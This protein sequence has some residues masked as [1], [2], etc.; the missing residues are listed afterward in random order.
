MKSLQDYIDKYREIGTNLGYTG[1]GIEVLV[2]LL[3]NASYIS[4]VENVS[5]MK[6]ASLE[7]CAL[8]NSKI[9]HCVDS[10]YSVFRGSCPRVL[11]KIKPT[12]YMTLTPY[13][14]IITSQTFKVYYL[15]YYTGSEF[16]YSTKTF[17]P[18]DS[19]S[20]E[21]QTIICLIAKETV[22]KSWTINAY[23][24]Y[25]VDCYESNLS[26]DMYVEIG[27][28][29]VNS[30]RLFSDHILKHYV[31]DLTL[32]D[33]GSRLYVANYYK[34]T[35]GRS[36]TDIV[37]MTENETIGATYFKFSL[38]G[39]Y[40]Q[41]ELTR[42]KLQGA[43]LVSFTNEEIIKCTNSTD[44]G[45]TESA[46]GI[47]YIKEISRDGLVTIHYK[48]NRDRYV[49]SILR[50][51]SD[52]GTVLEEAYPNIIKSGGTSYTFT[53]NNS[54][55]SIVNI[56][57][58]PMSESVLLSAD[59]IDLFKTEKRA[60]YVITDNITVNKGTRYIATFNISLELFNSSNDDLNTLIGDNIL[61][62]AYQR[63][64]NIEF[65]TG[66]IEEIKSL[67]SKISNV[68]R[69]NQLEIGYSDSNNVEVDL[70]KIDPSTSYFDI[71]YSIST[72]V[73]QTNTDF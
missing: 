18:I 67:I 26:S 51:N 11:L 30:T 59:D 61:Q 60:Y 57:Y 29:V 3:A 41:T 44:T 72:I 56:Y 43:V 45:L 66:T 52:I 12:K 6:E 22:D 69:I 55:S 32:P 58:I 23:N 24:T 14:E 5:Y 34:D 16:N 8:M 13:Q 28:K 47:Y 48:A 42:I 39:D 9:Q 4:E 25:Y 7:K 10:M 17:Y 68:K 15:G 70:A 21:T 38:L 20:T 33:F 64:F 31:F 53:Y 62:S 37:G 54:D 71:R 65:N 27:N 35:V 19:T 50:S 49:N 40:N 46:V 36:S 63:K 2:Q 73:T 1:Q